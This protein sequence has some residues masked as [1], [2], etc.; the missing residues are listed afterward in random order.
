MDANGVSHAHISLTGSP[1]FDFTE[2]RSTFV[3]YKLPEVEANTV[4]VDTYVSSDLLPLA[5]VFRPRVLFLDAGL[6]EVGDGKLDPM[7]KGSKFLGD[8]YYFA[9]TPI[10]PS[11]KYIVVYAASSANTDRL[12]ARSANGSLYGL[13]NAYEGDIS[14]I[15][16]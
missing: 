7:E 11:A 4:E 14:I 12:V 9:T 6:K 15:L 13:P 2:G 10:P 16:K 5:T 1:T 8:A 3:A